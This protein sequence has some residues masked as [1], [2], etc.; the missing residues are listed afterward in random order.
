MVLCCGLS[1]MLGLHAC[2]NVASIQS[3]GVL[4]LG[5]LGR[6]SPAGQGQPLPV[7]SRGLPGKSYKVTCG[8]SLPVLDLAAVGRGHTVNQGLLP[9]VLGL[10]RLSKRPRAP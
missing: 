5:T 1:A 10:G 7:T 9:P 2:Y 4:V 8:W 6:G 3:L